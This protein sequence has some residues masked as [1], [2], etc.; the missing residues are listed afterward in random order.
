MQTVLWAAPL[1][2]CTS[3][4]SFPSKVNTNTKTEL[5]DAQWHFTYKKR[6]ALL[7]LWLSYADILT[8][9]LTNLSPHASNLTN[10]S[11]QQK[12]MKFIILKSHC[13]PLRKLNGYPL[14]YFCNWV[15]VM[16]K[17]LSKARF[18]LFYVQTYLPTLSLELW[19]REIF[20]RALT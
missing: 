8:L 20:S 10:S 18:N 6:L 2:F 14:I 7:C 11:N 9:L 1:H 13:A 3:I 15:G 4:F 17:V 16:G 5:L 19:R 12:Q